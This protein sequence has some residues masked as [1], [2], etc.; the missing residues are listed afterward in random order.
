M[1]T[2]LGSSK[3]VAFI[4]ARGGS[5]G[6]PRKNLM[7]LRG[8]PLIY[9]GINAALSAGIETWVSTDDSEIAEWS[10]NFGARVLLRPT[11]L[12]QDNSPTEDAI[13]HFLGLTECDYVVMIQ[14][15]SPLIT[16]EDL[17]AGLTM[18]NTAEYDTLFSA[19][20]SNDILVWT[21]DM[22]PV[23][24]DYNARGNRQSRNRFIYIETGGFYIFGREGFLNCRNRLYG[25]IGAVE[26]PFWHSFEIDH[27][28]D[29]SQI[30]KLLGA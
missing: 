12:S 18:L 28:E 11:E 17:S 22:E 16:K 26:I 19:V 27:L 4:P 5:K 10:L 21:D 9:Y 25:R 23:N 13:S 15:T 1:D 24:Y 2:I 3:V 29:V 30:E 20:K 14:P 7:K 8:Q 6:I